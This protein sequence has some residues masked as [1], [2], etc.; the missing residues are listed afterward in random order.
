MDSRVELLKDEA[1]VKKFFSQSVK[2]FHSY[3]S[4]RD[5]FLQELKQADK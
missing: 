1:S 5:L 2:D 4:R 3:Q